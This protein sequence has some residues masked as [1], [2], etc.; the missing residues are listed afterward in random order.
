MKVTA[1][2]ALVATAISGNVYAA[3]LT[4]PTF[5]TPP[6]PPPATEEPPELTWGGPYLGLLGGYGISKLTI[7][8]WCEDWL[9]E[10]FPGGRLGAFAGHNW[11]ISNGFVAGIEGDLGYDWNS[12][13]F[14]GAREVGTGFTA[15]ARARIGYEVGAGLFYAAGGWTGANVYAKEPDDEQFANGW[16]LGIGVDWAISEKAF[17]RAEY[18]F[19]K[20]E[21]VEL[22]GIDTQF[23]QSVVNVGLAVAF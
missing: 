10:A 5:F 8:T 4:P 1:I 7:E 20:F 2:I 18:R 9:S 6:S 21:G 12:Q 13:A 15:S 23:D 16:T 14:N 11:S 3:D 17:V 19:D 22:D